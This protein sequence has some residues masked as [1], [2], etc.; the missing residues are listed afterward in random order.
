MVTVALKCDILCI[1]FW[2]CLL[3]LK[4]TAYIPIIGLHKA[5]CSLQDLIRREST[6]FRLKYVPAFSVSLDLKCKCVDHLH[7]TID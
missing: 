2:K 1:Y 4:T 3:R 5:D 7:N 6:S